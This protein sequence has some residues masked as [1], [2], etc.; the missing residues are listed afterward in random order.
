M[1]QANLKTFLLKLDEE[2]GKYKEYRSELNREPHTF[3]FHKV[4]LLN[5]TLKQ[6]R[7]GHKMDLDK[8]DE[9]AIKVIVDNAAQDLVKQLRVINGGT[10]KSPGGRTTLI[11]DKD[12][13][14]PIPKYRDISLPYTAFTR[15]KFAY[16]S[17]M[18]AMFTELQNYLRNHKTLDTIKTKNGSEKKSIM[19]F[20]D[21]GHDKN[22]GVFERFLDEK[23]AGIMN[24]LNNSIEKD[25]DK[26]RDKLLAELR[27]ATGINLKIKKVDDLSTIIIS[28][29]STS[30]NRSRGAQTGIKSRKIRK[31][32]KDFI[33]SSAIDEL[34]G[35]DSL[36]QQ[37]IQKT[38]NEIL[39][40]FRKV[41]N[42]TVSKSH[43]V[44]KSKQSTV[45]KKEKIK[46]TRKA[47]SIAV[48][49][50]ARK[51]KA[52]RKAKTSPA[53]SMLQMIAMINKELPDT[54]RKN[55][56]PPALENRSG[57]FADSVRVT[58]VAQTPR[59]FPSVGYTYQRRPYE[60]FEMGSPGPWSSPE[61]DPR[62][63]IDKSIREIAARMAI[64]R[65]YTR[66]V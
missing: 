21:A 46:A 12:T 45:S 65:F 2:L 7:K 60:V 47:A 23:T 16:R 64:G 26:A 6:L 52:R 34:K 55:M 56:Q 62:K 29:E 57:R 8:K 30:V 43:K 33:N 42:A 13:N 37:K 63:L 4:S 48:V 28:I 66:R 59:G 5:E 22:A 9:S 44:K 32:L 24:V 10:L 14:V 20:F 18:N 50:K 61:R 15:V 11:F 38:K 31:K 40:P 1:S 27:N 41:K 39:D 54:V 36:K 19:Y 35:S 49:A 25:S 51:T 17:S 53:S 3:V 58:E